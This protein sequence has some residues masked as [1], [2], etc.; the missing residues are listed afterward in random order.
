MNTKYP[1]IRGKVTS[2]TD[3]LIRANDTNVDLN[4]PFYAVNWF[5]TKVEWLYHFYNF[6]A[7]K[8]VRKVG[9]IAFFKAKVKEVLVG[10]AKDQREL[11]LIVR[12]PSGQQ[13]KS[14]MQSTYFKMVSIFRILSVSKFTFGFTHKIQLDKTSKKSDGLHYAIHHFKTQKDSTKVINQLSQYLPKEVQIKYTGAMI[15]NLYSQEKGAAASQIPN[16]MD[17]I[18]IVQSKD[19]AAIRAVFASTTYQNTLQKLTSS[20]SI[21]LLNRIF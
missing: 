15:A 10:D 17:A 9:G 7:V 18:I 16:L 5:D 11:L 20:S 4:Q 8:S 1:E 13:F 2:K 6:L 12:Y 14:L 19:E 3:V 21:S